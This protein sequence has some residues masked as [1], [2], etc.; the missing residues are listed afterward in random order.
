[1]T[2]QGGE[3]CDVV[4]MEPLTEGGGSTADNGTRDRSVDDAVAESASTAGSA[5]DV[6]DVTNSPDR[7]P[8]G[9]ERYD[10][11]EDIATKFRLVDALLEKL[12]DRS[13][14]VGATVHDLECSLEFSQHE[15]DVLKKENLQLRVKLG[16]QE[17]EDKR[18]QYQIKQVDDKLDRLETASKKKNLVIEGLPEVDGKKENVA[19]TISGFFDQLHINKE[20]VFEACYRMGP[21]SRGRTRPVLVSFE[22]QMD[23]DIVYSKRFDL[24]NTTAF[25]RVWINEDL[26][27]QRGSV[28]SLGS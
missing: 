6:R 24:R 22:R 23:R 8:R 27:R 9:E 3:P 18:T 2:I 26:G 17:V 13:V 20:V 25:Q 5:N 10:N 16:M 12:N 19:K 4:D 21:Y 11:H 1:M 15:I 7:Y 28:G 14:K